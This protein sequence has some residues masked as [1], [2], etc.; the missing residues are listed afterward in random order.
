MEI[1]KGRPAELL[2]RRELN[3]W[4]RSPPACNFGDGTIRELWSDPGAS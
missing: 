1:R 2:T 3:C 4:E